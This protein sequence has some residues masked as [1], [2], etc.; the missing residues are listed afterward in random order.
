MEINNYGT[1]DA[2]EFK[3]QMDIAG[4]KTWE[5]HY[6][7]KKH[8]IR[9]TVEVQEFMIKNLDAF[10]YKIMSYLF[11]RSFTGMATSAMW[12]KETNIEIG[13]NIGIN[14]N[15]IKNNLIK[16]EEAGMIRRYKRHQRDKQHIV[17]LPFENWKV[18]K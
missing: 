9:I 11:Y 17:I 1:T 3:G 10:Q 12:V 8:Y 6:E 7:G 2:L 16:F 4:A 14:K 5:E 13:E 18:I 15:V